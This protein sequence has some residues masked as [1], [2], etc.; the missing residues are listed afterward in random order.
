MQKVQKI[1]E[2]SQG[3][4]IWRIILTDLDQ[5]VVEE[6]DIQNKEVYFSCIDRL[7]GK[8]FWKNKSFLNEKFWIGI[9][10][11]KSNY[12]ILHQFEKPDMPMHKKI[13][14][15]DLKSGDIL[16]VNDDLTFYDIDD[17]FI[18]GYL[19]N[20]DNLEFYQLEIESG[21]IIAALGNEDQ[22]R[23]ILSSIP[24]KDY[25]RYIFTKTLGDD[26]TEQIQKDIVSALIGDNLLFNLCEFIDYND[27]F[28]F[29]YYDKIEPHSLIN[30]L[31]IYDKVDKKPILFE[32]LNQSTP[33]PVPD[34]FFM[35]D[36]YLYFIQ[37]K[38]KL[39]GY[40]LLS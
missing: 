18:Y 9:E 27:Y 1:F 11:T 29:S 13:I 24:E 39:I 12:L 6:R 15:V 37:N 32:I 5:I 23:P 14:N 4:N 26:D 7:K 30:R 2:Y 22:S 20:L 40:R 35:Y 3:R 8:I 16:W 33:A 36:N 17:K 21:N 38:V 19:H 28:I 10:G 31:I 34:S 25:S